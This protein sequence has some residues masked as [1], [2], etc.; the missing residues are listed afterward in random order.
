MP[1][2]VC[3]WLVTIMKGRYRGHEMASLTAASR[4]GHGG[5]QA[6][7]LAHPGTAASQE[8]PLRTWRSSSPLQALQHM[9]VCCWLVSP[10][11]RRTTAVKKS[12]LALP[13]ARKQCSKRCRSSQGWM[14]CAGTSCGRNLWAG[15]SDRAC[16]ARKARCLRHR[17]PH[18]SG[19]HSLVSVSFL[20]V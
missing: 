15:R 13:R 18:Q 5:Q 10:T 14:F 19:R 12:A 7:S 11:S 2:A 1:F 20:R 3:G 4:R 8:S 6:W 9:A 16:R 17:S